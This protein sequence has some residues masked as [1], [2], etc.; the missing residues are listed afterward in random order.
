MS[1]QVNDVFSKFGACCWGLS[2]ITS[3][4]AKSEALSRLVSYPGNSP[5]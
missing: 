3:S 2:V 5:K 1:V 4:E